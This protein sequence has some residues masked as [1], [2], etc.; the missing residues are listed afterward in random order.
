MRCLSYRDELLLVETVFE[1]HGCRKGQQMVKA[2]V[3]SGCREGQQMVKAS[4]L[5]S[6][7]LLRSFFRHRAHRFTMQDSATNLYHVTVKVI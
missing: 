2:S 5:L 7:S 6:L 4:V 3:P 1:S